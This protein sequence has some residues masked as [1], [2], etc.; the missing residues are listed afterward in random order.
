M[1]NQ[2]IPG[3][4]LNNTYTVIKI[5]GKGGMGTV[6]LAQEVNNPGKNYAIKE[7]ISTFSSPSQEEIAQKTFRT[8]IE[9]LSQLNHRQLPRIY[10]TFT[11]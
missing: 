2:L 7:L 8:E 11:Q 9:F 5:L 6:Y 1:I 10:G 4:L 3:T